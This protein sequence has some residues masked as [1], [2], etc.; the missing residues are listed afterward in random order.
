MSVNWIQ[1]A[2]RN[3]KNSFRL[4]FPKSKL[5]LRFFFGLT[6]GKRATK[7]RRQQQAAYT[8]Q[9]GH[10]GHHSAHDLWPGRRATV[11]REAGEGMGWGR[12]GALARWMFSTLKKRK[13]KESVSKG[14]VLLHWHFNSRY[15]WFMA[16]VLQSGQLRPQNIFHRLI[17][18]RNQSIRLLNPSCKWVQLHFGYLL[19]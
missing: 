5:R 16:N 1:H 10:V 19:E 9:R 6:Q 14:V 11:P 12:V 8:Q 7:Q 2:C 18:E 4:R 13:I 17:Y 15:S 3:K